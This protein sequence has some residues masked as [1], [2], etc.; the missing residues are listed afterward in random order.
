MVMITIGLG[1]WSTLD[2]VQRNPAK[3]GLAARLTVSP[4]TLDPASAW[5]LVNHDPDVA[6]AYRCVRVTALLPG[7]ST[8]ITTLGMGTSAHPYPFRVVQGRLYHAPE[9]AVATQGLLD[10]LGVRVGEFVQMPFGGVLVTFR[11]VGRIIDPQ[12]DGQVLAYGRDTLADEGAAAPPVFYSLVLR[13][14]RQPGRRPGLAGP[15]AQAGGWISAR[16]PTRPD[17]LGVVRF[18]IAGRDRRAGAD[19]ADQPHHRVRRRAAR[20]PARRPGAARHGADP[21]PG[22]DRR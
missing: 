19:R 12:Y 7:E 2:E 9:E 11:I 1:F 4:G 8:T 21:G 20:P 14:L 17:Q 3:I 22:P 10:L 18:L 16:W 15:P 5:Q 6:A 13:G